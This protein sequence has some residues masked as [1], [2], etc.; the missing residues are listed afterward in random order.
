V[1]ERFTTNS[2]RVIVLAQEEARRLHHDYI[3]TEHELLG[4]LS[5][6]D[7][8][9]QAAVGDL[10]SRD[11]ARVAVEEIIGRG[12]GVPSG[13]IPFTPR[14]KKV[15]ELSLREAL[16]LRHRSIQ[17]GHVFLGLLREGEGVGAQ[18]LAQAGVDF[19]QAGARIVAELDRRPDEPAP[20][21]EAEAPT[22]ET[23]PE[24]V[25]TSL[26]DM[27]TEAA[28][29]A[30]ERAN[31]V[32]APPTPWSLLVAIAGGEGPAA[33]LLAG[34]DPTATAPAAP[35]DPV[36]RPFLAVFGRARGLAGALGPEP[37]RVDVLHLLAVLLSPGEGSVAAELEARGTDPV[38]LRHQALA[39]L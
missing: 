11:Q 10:L 32:G 30:I 15:L 19:E 9:V 6:D 33:E 21:A 39:L 29:A 36:G 13:H 24:R 2:R 20:E 37:V 1:F 34:L 35:P 25:I 26:H 4:L 17:P 23:D 3:G 16:R 7:P 27:V 18:V 28:A 12:E 5:V 22:F 31:T 14:A 38:A 8:V